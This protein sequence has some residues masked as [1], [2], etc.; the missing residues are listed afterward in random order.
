MKIVLFVLFE[1]AW[2]GIILGGNTFAALITLVYLV[3]LH[4]LTKPKLK[5]WGWSFGL[6]SLGFGC[7]AILTYFGVYQFSGGWP[8]LWLACLW[9]I[10]IPI[11]PLVLDW[12]FKK[13]WLAPIAGA[14][15]GPL[16]YYAGSLLSEMSIHSSFFYI[17]S[18]VAWFLI[19]LVLVYVF[20]H[21]KRAAL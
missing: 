19:M 9:L 14:I 21:L 1:A 12:L 15:S 7:D 2:F 4:L 3:I 13:P 18:A 6:A 16:T 20:P 10:F 8:P 17:E 11:V 5:F